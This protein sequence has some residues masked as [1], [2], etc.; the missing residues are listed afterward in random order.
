VRDL[1]VD[2]SGEYVEIEF[3]VDNSGENVNQEPP[4]TLREQ[5]LDLVNENGIP[6][7]EVPAI[8]KRVTNVSKPSSE[9]TVDQLTKVINFIKLTTYKKQ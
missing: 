2:N 7:A 3:D 9:L 6:H 1:P 5:L 8:I 4:R